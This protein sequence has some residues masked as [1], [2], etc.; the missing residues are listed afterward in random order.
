MADDQFPF[1]PDR[2]SAN[3]FGQRTRFA[4]QS[5]GVHVYTIL[6]GMNSIEKENGNQNMCALSFSFQQLCTV[7]K[8]NKKP[9]A[10]KTIHLFLLNYLCK[11]ID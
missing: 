6:I 5:N 1:H 7:L 4:G 9:P 3:D 11:N 2:F 8:R 10:M